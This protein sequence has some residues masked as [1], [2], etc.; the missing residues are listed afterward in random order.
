M[1]LSSIRWSRK[2]ALLLSQVILIVS[3]GCGPAATPIIIELPTATPAPGQPTQPPATPFLPTAIPTITPT[4]FVPRAIIKIFSHVPLT[5][6]QAE[7]GTDILRGTELAIQRLSGPLN[8]LEYKVEL[9]SY[10]DQGNVGVAR[11]NAQ[12]I[13][14][15]PQILCG[16]GHYDS[17]ITIS[18]SDIYH[19]AGL[20][21]IAP[22]TTA[23]LFTDRDYLETNRLIARADGQGTVA[24]QFA[25]SQGYR[26]FFILT[27]QAQTSLR[28]AESFRTQ[29]GGLGIQWLGSVIIDTTADS[30]AAIVSRII[31]AGPDI[32]Y[33]ST[34]ADR[35]MPFLLALRAAGYEGTFLGT[36][37]LDNPALISQAGS[38]LLQGGGLFYTISSPPAEFHPDTEQF[39]WD[40]TNQ[41]GSHPLSFA[42]R[43]YDATGM[44]LRAIERAAEAKA[45]ELPTRNEVAR[46]L[47]RVNNYKGLTGEY[48]FNRA[49]DPELVQYYVHQVTTVDLDSWAQNPI[50]AVYEIP[51]P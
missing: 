8:E 20:P 11:A 30:T 25:Q 45:G 29:S 19:L 34:S 12:T 39:I 1:N 37:D 33:I 16:V 21:F 48:E 27:E 41:Y 3:F 4:T 50:V 5:G 44:C 13:V 10:D 23:P 18:A 6:E 15:D 17:E 24:A 7:F 51:P 35:A 2:I 42:A 9:V 47:R 38:S 46:A 40:Y 49:G 32:V 26:S 43:A 14:A 22:S 36:E 28:N 31:S